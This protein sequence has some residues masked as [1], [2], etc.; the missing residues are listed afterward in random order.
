MTPAPP[1]IDLRSA[2]F[3]YADRAVVFDVTLTVDAGDSVAMLGPNGSG[4]STLVKG[5]LG[6]ATHFAGDVDVFG[7]PLAQLTDRA[8]IGYVPQRHT[9]ASGARATV[10]EIVAS[11]RLPRRRWLTA[12]SRADRRAIDGALELVGLADRGK[13]DVA[14][15]SGGQQ[16]RALIARALAGDP[17]ILL[18]DE[19]TAGVDASSQLVLARVLGRLV[20]AGK[21]LVVVT[22][23]LAALAGVLTRVVVIDQGRVVF[24]GTSD[25]FA[26]AEKGVTAG[27]PAR[28]HLAPVVTLGAHHHD[29]ELSFPGPN[30]A[31]SLGPLA[32]RRGHG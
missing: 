4:K 11:G 27:A 6:L 7:M 1:V 31:P 13:T 28:G 17:D 18:M 9:L 32:P 29:D 3:G 2:S 30:L 14:A 19:P 26:S 8:R 20:A 23:E 21:T 10:R 15:L 24:D 16:R 5:M 22:H 12:P 25:A